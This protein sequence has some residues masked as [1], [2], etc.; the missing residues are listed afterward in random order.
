MLLQDRVAVI[1]GAGRGIG[2][3]IARLFVDEGCRVMINDVERD[4]ADEAATFCTESA[5]RSHVHTSIGSI[6]D[7]HYVES[8]MS[9]TVSEF[10]SIDILVNNAGITRD[11]MIHKMSEEEWH[12]VLDVN[13][14]GTFRC[15]RAAA[16]FLRDPAKAEIEATGDVRYHRKIVNFFST[17]A[18]HGN[19]GQANYAAAKMGNVGL[20]RSLAREWAPFRINVN[21]VAPG[22][23][24]TRMTQIKEDAA[25]GMGIPRARR[26]ELLQK[27][28]FGRPASPEDV[29]RVVLFFASPLSD[30]VTGQTIN[31]SGGQQIP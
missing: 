5:T 2:R 16:P 27:L 3:A 31:V 4:P 15:I 23:T 14:G 19:I 8:L 9:E 18:I 26:D 21:C 24:D 11:G 29:A 10:G 17:S 30:W 7:P 25:S 12:T 6:A 1:T 22:F 13:L 20:T 28:P